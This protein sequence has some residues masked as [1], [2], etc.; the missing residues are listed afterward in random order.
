MRYPKGL[1]YP[2][3]DDSRA[4]L[5]GTRNYDHYD[6]LPAVENN[7]LSLRSILTGASVGGFSPEHCHAI[8]DAENPSEL[9]IHIADVAGEARDVL[10]IYSSGH[11]IVDFKDDHKLKLALRHTT[12]RDLRYTALAVDVITTAIRDSPAL[13]K[14]LIL[15]CC[16][17]A[18]VLGSIAMGDIGDQLQEAATVDGT[19]TLTSSSRHDVSIAP[20]GADYTAFSEV[21]IKL[22]EAPARG[23]PKGLKLGAIYSEIRQT[24]KALGYPEPKQYSSSTAADLVLVGFAEQGASAGPVI[25]VPRSSPARLSPSLTHEQRDEGDAVEEFIRLSHPNDAEREKL[26]PRNREAVDEFLQGCLGE[27]GEADKRGEEGESPAKVL[28][29]LGK[30]VTEMIR[31]SNSEHP[32]VL[33]ARDL[34][35]FWLCRAR[36]YEEAKTLLER[37][38]RARL[39]TQGADHKDVLAVRHN[40]AHVI[41]LAGDPEQATLEFESLVGDRTE[42]LGRTDPATL[43]SRD[44]LGH[45][46]GL[47]GD[48]S[49]AVMIY[50]ELLA[51]LDWA[52]G[53]NE[54][55]TLDIQAKLGRWLGA[56]GHAAEASDTFA[57]V[58]AA[59]EVI[60]GTEG[61]NVILFTRNR[62]YWAVKVHDE[63]HS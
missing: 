58:A 63:E 43:Q 11:G 56:A 22:L 46:T 12:P 34:Q 32:Q 35:A 50:R 17:A 48:A 27:A 1:R 29:S 14:V 9:G 28:V 42:I 39:A 54:E 59:W 52:L 8:I 13:I 26:G 2:K 55:E 36:R 3:R 40:L 60:E 23:H 51:D 45:W 6:A 53:T 47:A 57:R 31:C 30:I 41:G 24:L 16:Y 33:L 19:Y 25:G 37:V 10:L 4:I 15:E 21:L 62:D 7:V 20:P 44:G 38:V 5:L 18:A 61:S 49:N